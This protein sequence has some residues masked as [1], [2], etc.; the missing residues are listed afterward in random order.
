VS[1]RNA[2]P[3]LRKEETRPA[4]RPLQFLPFKHEVDGSLAKDDKLILGE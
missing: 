3:D 4:A 1:N 2:W